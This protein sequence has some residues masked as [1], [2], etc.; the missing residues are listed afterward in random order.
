MEEQKSRQ[1]QAISVRQ[2]VIFHNEHSFS[3]HKITL[4]NI[5]VNVYH[6]S[7]QVAQ[8]EKKQNDHHVPELLLERVSMS[9]FKH[10]LGPRLLEK[11][12][13]GDYHD[14]EDEE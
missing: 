5:E 10:S 6:E 14:N 2:Y 7:H 12:N 13:V 4:L 1:G 3:L 11:G 9:L 8:P